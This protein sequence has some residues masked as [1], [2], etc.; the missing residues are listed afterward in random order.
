MKLKA[1]FLS[2]LIGIAVFFT[3]GN[4][5][6]RESNIPQYSGTQPNP[7]SSTNANSPILKFD[8]FSEDPSDNTN[9][10]NTRIVNI[11]NLI[12]F[13]VISICRSVSHS[14]VLNKFH[15]F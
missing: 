12:I 8:I 2:L 9:Y 10:A 1:F 6:A 3:A 15:I 14:L 11:V 7:G 5:W 4:V 13:I